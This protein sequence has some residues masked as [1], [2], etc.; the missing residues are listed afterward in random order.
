[1]DE[2]MNG[3][4]DGRGEWTFI[5]EIGTSMIDYVIRNE[6]SMEAI[7]EVKEGER[8]ESNH[9]SFEVQLKIVIGGIGNK[10]ARR[11]DIIERE[12]SVWSKEGIE[13]YR[14]KC[15]GWISTQVENEKIWEE[16]R[17]K[18]K[19]SIMKI[20]KRIIPWKLRRK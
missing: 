7:K 18:V 15:K 13:H 16:L 1:M 3:C 5:G 4:Y 11:K 10:Q 6:K 9:V 12:R 8:T 19:S 2:I 17:E 20:S 14:E